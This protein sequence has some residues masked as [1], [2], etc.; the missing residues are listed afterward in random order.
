MTWRWGWRREVTP[1]TLL[2]ACGSRFEEEFEGKLSGKLVV[3]EVPVKPGELSPANFQSRTAGQVESERAFFRQSELFL[4]TF[5][6]I[7]KSDRAF[8]IAHAHAFDW[9]AFALG[10]L[11]SVPVVHTVHLPALDRHINAIIR[12]TYE[13]TGSSRAVT[14]SKACAQT[15]AADFLS[16]G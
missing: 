16:I 7:N 11:S 3:V 12:T 1:V 2:A 6:D 9:P 13:N 8:D 15:Y 14:V 10:P 5:L 4:Q